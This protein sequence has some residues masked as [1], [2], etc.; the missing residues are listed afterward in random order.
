[1]LPLLRGQ[2]FLCISV[3]KAFPVAAGVVFSPG[4]N[5]PVT[6]QASRFTLGSWELRIKWGARHGAAAEDYGGTHHAVV[7]AVLA[8]PPASC[9]FPLILIPVTCFLSSH[10]SYFLPKVGTGGMAGD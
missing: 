4:R 5:T 8:Y 10:T 7:T 2:K 9:C 1:M 3:R 6:S